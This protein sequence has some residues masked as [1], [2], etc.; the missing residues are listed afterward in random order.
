MLVWRQGYVYCLF[1]GGGGRVVVS[2]P[3]DASLYCL[4]LLKIRWGLKRGSCSF[5]YVWVGVSL[6]SCS[7]LACPPTGA[8]FLCFFYSYCVLV[9][10]SSMCMPTVSMVQK[11]GACVFLN[12]RLLVPERYSRHTRESKPVGTQQFSRAV[13]YERSEMFIF[14]PEPRPRSRF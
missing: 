14:S 12:R 3:T 5:T 4:S 1:C 9:L 8:A 7:M 6:L 13:E 11:N 2:Q 10:F